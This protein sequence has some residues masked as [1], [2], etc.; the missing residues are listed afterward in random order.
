MSLEKLRQNKSREGKTL[1]EYQANE[2][3]YS[4][5]KIL[6]DAYIS[7]WR[8]TNQENV[9]YTMSG[10]AYSNYLLNKRFKE[11]KEK[12]NTRIDDKEE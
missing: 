2:N 4:T 3:I 5:I 10:Y 7:T 11:A 6:M 9:F 1:L 8:L 12:K